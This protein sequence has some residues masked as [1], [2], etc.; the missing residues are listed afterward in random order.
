[1][2]FR[3]DMKVRK[4]D[5][6]TLLL[7]IG[8]AGCAGA[9]VILFIVAWAL[10]NNVGTTPELPKVT[11]WIQAWSSVGGV[12]AGLAAA[13]AAA[14]LLMF[15]RNRAA[16]AERQLA[17]ER[18]EA[19]LNVARAVVVTGADLGGFGG[20][21]DPHINEVVFKIHNYGS[22]PIQNV[23]AVVK[24]PMNGNY[25]I[26]VNEIRGPGGLQQVRKKLKTAVQVA[27]PWTF[28]AEKAPVTVCFIDYANQAWQRTSD[29]GV[30]R[31]TVP[32]PLVAHAKGSH[33]QYKHPS[34]PGRV[35]IAGKPSRDLPPGLERSI[36][37]QA[38]LTG[39]TQ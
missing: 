35:T 13:S 8:S 37:K 4:I 22:S 14:F 12:F 7:I 24:L 25:L 20:E 36:L 31:T 29:G 10:P 2:R 30:A 23:V 27:P 11:D 15:E 34:K 26:R 32:Y 17:E 16:T 21:D 28:H 5:R 3:Q 19:A 9:A 38:G 39:G 6:T 1:M 18:A 33:R